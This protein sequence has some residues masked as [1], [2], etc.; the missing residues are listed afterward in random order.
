MVSL[1]WFLPTALDAIDARNGWT[2]VYVGWEGRVHGCL[3]LAD[4]PAAR[5]GRGG[6]GAACPRARSAAAQRRRT[7]PG[8]TPGEAA[9][10]PALACRARPGGQGG[11]HS[12]LDAAVRG[13]VA[14]VGDGLNDG[15]VLAAASVG[16]AVGGGTDLAKESAD[17]VLP[18]DGLTLLPWVLDLAREVRRSIRANLVWAFGYNAA[19]LSLAAAGLLQPVLA[20]ALMAG[21]SLVIVARTLHGRSGAEIAAESS[22][23]VS[24]D[25]Q[26]TGVEGLGSRHMKRLLSAILLGILV[27]TG[28]DDALSR[29][30]HPGASARSGVRRVAH[31]RRRAR[32]YG[33]EPLRHARSARALDTPRDG[34]QPVRRALRRDLVGPVRVA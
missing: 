13:S 23:R 19:A 17:L 34:G 22:R 32:R 31:R 27:V 25:R 6:L 14:M 12:R 26:R 30:P 29:D 10:H 28:C 20:A 24:G 4:T 15:P 7:D 1:G 9:G 5:G 8:R 16:I 3:A 11:L 2:R 18:D 21:S 33:R